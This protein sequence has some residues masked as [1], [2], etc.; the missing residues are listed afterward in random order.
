MFAQSCPIYCIDIQNNLNETKIYILHLLY[1]KQCHSFQ[2]FEC[3]CN[4]EQFT[5][6]KCY[7]RY[8][9]SL[10]TLLLLDPIFENLQQLPQCEERNDMFST[11]SQ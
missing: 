9:S 7:L 11:W 8:K 6:L 5:F 4:Y 10:L 1:F 3:L 2:N